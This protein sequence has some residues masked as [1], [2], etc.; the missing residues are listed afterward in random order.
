MRH[1]IHIEWCL[2]ARAYFEA[3]RGLCRIRHVQLAW[4]HVKEKIGNTN[5]LL[6]K[7]L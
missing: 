7:D 2:N 1:D 3:Y 6:S 4:N 5:R